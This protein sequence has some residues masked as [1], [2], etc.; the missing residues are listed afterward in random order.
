[1]I[2]RISSGILRILLLQ[3]IETMGDVTIQTTNDDINLGSTI[4]SHVTKVD[5]FVTPDSRLWNPYDLGVANLVMQSANA[6]INMHEARA[7]GDIT[8]AAPNGQVN[9]IAPGGLKGIEGGGTVSV[10]DSDGVVYDSEIS[11]PPVD[12][13]VFVGPG[14]PAIPPGPTITSAGAPAVPGA[15]PPLAP[16]GVN[17][18]DTAAPGSN[19]LP[20]VSSLPSSSGTVAQPGSSLPASGSTPGS[21][22]TGSAQPGSTLPGASS[23]PGAMDIA[24][25]P[26]TTGSATV[27]V[28][29]EIEIDELGEIE[30]ASVD[31]EEMQSADDISQDN[32][33]D[34]LSEEDQVSELDSFESPLETFITSA[35][36]GLF[37]VSS[38]QDAQANPLV[39]DTF[40]GTFVVFEY[41]DEEDKDFGR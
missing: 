8:I 38:E 5:F 31:L 35:E 26:P 11:Q 37:L 36:E 13:I 23:L 10:T 12:R 6:D 22:G 24:S 40:D 19:T 30:V 1:M 25:A 17:V 16:V 27:D 14:A 18:A 33:Q 4:G 39:F 28:I 34:S 3:Q 29:N 15:L 20:G 41:E 2:Q 7:E 9:F 21:T 32:N